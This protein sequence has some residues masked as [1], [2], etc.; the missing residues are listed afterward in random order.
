MRI[1]SI[2]TIAVLF[3]I[4][5]AC[6]PTVDDTVDLEDCVSLTNEM[7]NGGVSL[8]KGCYLVDEDIKVNEGLLTLEPGV[9]IFFDRE[10]GLTISGNGSLS[11]EGTSTERVKLTG[12]VDEP[13]SWTGLY[14]NNSE[15]SLNLLQYTTVEFGGGK[16]IGDGLGVA[17]IGLGAFVGSSR[18]V[19]KNTIVRDSKEKGMIIKQDS[20]FSGFSFNV[21]ENN[22]DYALSIPADQRAWIDSGSDFVGSS[23]ISGIQVYGGKVDKNSTWQPLKGD[24]FTSVSDEIKVHA[25]LVIQPAVEIHFGD[26]VGIIIEGRF[27]GVLIAAGTAVKPIIFTRLDTVQWRGIYIDNSESSENIISNAIIEYG[28]FSAFDFKEKA[29]LAIGGFVG[30]SNIVVK[31]CTISNSAGSGIFL[32]SDSVTNS[33]IAAVNSFSENIGQNI[34]VK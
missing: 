7:I 33:D 19:M 8:E 24:A 23:N 13:G 12:M 18:L 31:D 14:F 5:S 30:V 28:G 21:F 22:G 9:E 15:S 34:W 6:G 16:D 3:V 25:R 26:N 29:N 10:T 32:E 1:S 17:N 11:S 2:K 20:A 27:D 4:L